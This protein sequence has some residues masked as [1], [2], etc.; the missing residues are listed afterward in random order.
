MHSILT[1]RWVLAF[2][3]GAFLVGAAGL[4]AGEMKF[5][6]LGLLISELLI[7]YAAILW[8]TP[9]IPPFSSRPAVTPGLEQSP[10][11]D[12]PVEATGAG[13]EVEPTTTTDQRLLNDE[14][15]KPRA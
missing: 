6:P 1:P 10:A 13:V 7:I 12:A 3:L 8:T 15:D 2:A 14:D 5:S 4:F 11:E 9:T